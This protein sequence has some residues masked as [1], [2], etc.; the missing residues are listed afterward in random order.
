[1]GVFQALL[2]GKFGADGILAVSHQPSAVSRQEKPLT[3]K[4]A[5]GRKGTEANFLMADG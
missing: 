2:P 1:L 3:A 5:K 4:F